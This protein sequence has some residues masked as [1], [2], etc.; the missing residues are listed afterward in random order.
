M[1]YDHGGGD[2]SGDDDDDDDDYTYNTNMA[3]MY[4]RRI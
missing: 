1:L 2:Y 3:T 4:I